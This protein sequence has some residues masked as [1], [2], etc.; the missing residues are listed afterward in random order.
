MEFDEAKVDEYALAL[1]YLSLHDDNRAWKALD[2]SITDRLYQKGLIENPRDK[3]KSIVF[4]PEGLLKSKELFMKFFGE[5]S[6]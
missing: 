3:N 2:W 5:R 4:T 1:L 6:S